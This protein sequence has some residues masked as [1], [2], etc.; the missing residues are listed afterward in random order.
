[1]LTIRVQH[2]DGRIETLSLREP[3]RVVPGRELDRLVTAEME[4][5]FT[6]AGFYDGWGRQTSCASAEA[7]EIVETVERQRR[8]A[9]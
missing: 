2:E 9:D 8:F 7:R 5:F 1:M 6:K 4:H 3:L